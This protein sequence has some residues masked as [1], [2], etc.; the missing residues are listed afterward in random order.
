MRKSIVFALAALFLAASVQSGE[1][2]VLRL[3]NETAKGDSQYVGAEVFAKKAAE[4]SGGVIEVQLFPG[5]VLGSGPDMINNTKDGKQ[6][7]YLGGCGF[8]TTWDGRL[9]V[10]DIPY[11][12]GNVEQAHKILD[13]DFGQ[14]MLSVIE[15]FGLKGLAF[16]ENGIRHVTNS[17][18]PIK[19]PADLKGL[20]MRVMPGNPVHIEIWKLF[21]TEPAPLTFSEIYGALQSK[22]FDGQ[23]HPIAPIYSGKFY[24]V[25]K[26]LSKTGHVY[27]PLI[28]VMNKQKFD[29][30]APEY[31]KALV[32]AARAGALAQRKFIKDN[33]EKFIA[34]M[35][36]K[37]MEII[38]VDIKPFRDLVRPPIEKQFIEKNGDSWLK[39][40]ESML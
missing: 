37:G 18:R 39:K 10:F 2:I 5:S 32:E 21:G 17:A 34:D 6:D 4:L 20:K 29:S 11:L 23:E 7:M 27:G 15:P 33:E 22:K 19:T 25:Q 1:K 24:E 9:N 14:E 28:L 38:D 12:F 26:Y 40:I 36:S 8:Y 3:G 35:K 16:W 31:Q 30:L 13:S